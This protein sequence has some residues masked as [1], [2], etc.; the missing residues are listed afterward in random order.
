MELPFQ[1]HPD[2]AE[3]RRVL[4]AEVGRMRALFSASVRPGAGNTFEWGGHRR[5]VDQERWLVLDA[6]H[7]DSYPGATTLP[8]GADTE[9]ALEFYGGE[10]RCLFGDDA[11]DVLSWLVSDTLA[12]NGWWPSTLQ[13]FNLLAVQPLVNPA[14]APLFWV[15]LNQVMF[16]D[17]SGDVMAILR[18]LTYDMATYPASRGAAPQLR[19]AQ[20]DFFRA[21]EAEP[22]PDWASLDDLAWAQACKHLV[23]QARCGIESHVFDLVRARARDLHDERE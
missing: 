23:W 6:R 15:A 2:S 9:S 17:A 22:P 20:A 14:C 11:I 3:V 7:A 18:P 4:G 16:N 21:Q 8:V 10:S 13:L 12:P 19:A 5:W 1:E